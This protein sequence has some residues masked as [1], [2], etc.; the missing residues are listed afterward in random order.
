MDITRKQ[1]KA[2]KKVSWKILKSFKRRKN[3]KQ[4]H[5]RERHKNFSEEEKDKQYKTIDYYKKLIIIK[6]IFEFFSLAG[7]GLSVN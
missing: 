3:K 5:G 6:R 2:S 1:R 4:K 7:P